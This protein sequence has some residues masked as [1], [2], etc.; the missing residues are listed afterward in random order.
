MAEPPVILAL[1][2]NLWFQTRLRGAA[3]SVGAVVE[4]VGRADQLAERAGRVRPAL[5][6]V[7]MAT[8]G[9]DW[10]AAIRAIRSDGVTATVPIVAFGPHVDADGQRLARQAGADRVLSNRAFTDTLPHVL[11]RYVTAPNAEGAEPEA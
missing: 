5:I 11:A 2:H 4:P 3:E 6:V 8:P 7:D 9:Q 10:A 1:A